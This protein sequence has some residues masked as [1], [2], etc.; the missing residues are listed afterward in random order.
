MT[1][2][3]SL[4]EYR[5]TNSHYVSTGQ[6]LAL[7]N[8]G[9]VNVK[10]TVQQ[11]WRTGRPK[12]TGSNVRYRDKITQGYTITGFCSLDTK[13]KIESFSK[14]N[15]KYKVS[16]ANFKMG[17]P[18]KDVDSWDTSADYEKVYVIISKVTFT[19]YAGSKGT[20]E[21][22][23]FQYVLTLVRARTDDITE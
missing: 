16:W 21:K 2:E 22:E 18:R 11:Y 1:L 17:S 3:L 23:L 4:I 13:V 10:K 14:R 20:G 15:S 7:E 6:S 19:R 9:P 8:P 5:K 12:E